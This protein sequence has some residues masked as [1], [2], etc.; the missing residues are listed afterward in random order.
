[1]TRL[2]RREENERT[3]KL[4]DREMMSPSER[5]EFEEIF[6]DFDDLKKKDKTIH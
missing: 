6:D 1:M 4:M 3:R 2:V 5:E